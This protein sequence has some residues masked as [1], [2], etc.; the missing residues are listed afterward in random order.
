M[1]SYSEA[2]KAGQG[3]E[4]AKRVLKNFL[5]AIKADPE[6]PSGMGDL[7]STDAKM[8]HLLK[9][10]ASLDES[11]VAGILSYLKPNGP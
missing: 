11:E 9:A 6:L 10:F 3:S 5:D 2:S 8:Q 4:G 1:K 7:L